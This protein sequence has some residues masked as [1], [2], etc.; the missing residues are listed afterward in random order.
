MPNVIIT[1]GGGGTGGT[2]FRM[3][4]IPNVGTYVDGVWQVGTAGFL[5]QE[6]VDIDRVEVLRGPQGTMFGRDST[7][8]A[9]RIWTKR[10]GRGIRR[11]RHRD[12]RLLRSARRQ[13]SLDLPISDT[14]VTKWTGA[15]LFRDGYIQS[16]TTGEDQGGIDQPVFRGDILWTPTERLDSGSTIRTT[17]TRSPSRAFR[18]RCSVPTTTRH[19]AGEVII[20]LPEMYTYVGVDYR[21]RP[22]EPF[23]DP[24]QP[25]RG[26]PRRQVGQF[27]N[28]SNSTLPN[29][30]DTEQASLETN[31]D[32]SDAMSLQFLTAATEQD[33]DSVIDW[34]NSQYDLVLDMNRSELDVS[35]RRSSSRAAGS[36]RV[37][38]RHLLLGPETI[39]RNGRW[40]VNEFQQG[41]MNPHNVFANPVCNPVRQRSTRRVPTPGV[42]DSGHPWWRFVANPHHREASSTSGMNPGQIGQLG[43]APRTG[44][45]ALADL[46]AGLFR[47]DSGG[48]FDTL[49][50]SDQ[51]GWAAS[52]EVTIHFG[53]TLDL[54]SACGTTTR[55][56]TR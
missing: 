5:T 47:R 49:S 7:G 53:D 32:I 8:G 3:R 11:Q 33:A 22:V 48:A 52:G 18:T 4:G 20:G 44:P 10:P 38:G 9:M 16:L 26:L 13:G 34:D 2:G 35:A 23:F 40:Q 1:G 46:P 41:L 55:A 27:E 24:A 51:D 29:R 30:Y 6:F 45:G 14:L 43:G 21:N 15:N 17:R 54:R 56:A 25:G 28:R 42:G 39:T 37:V 31:W 50:R 19:R 36:H 12:D